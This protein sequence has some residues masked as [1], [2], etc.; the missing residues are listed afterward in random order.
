MFT[1]SV[2]YIFIL[3]LF[4]GGPLDVDRVVLGEGEAGTGAPDLTAEVLANENMP[5]NGEALDGIDGVDGPA[6]R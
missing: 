5:P 6:E 2:S 1:V 4:A 3:I